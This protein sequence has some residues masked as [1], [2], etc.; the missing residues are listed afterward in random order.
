[1]LSFDLLSGPNK[2]LSQKTWLGGILT[3]FTLLALFWLIHTEYL[4]FSS[5]RVT[6]TIYVDNTSKPEPIQVNLS[7][8]LRNAPCSLITLDLHDHL[9]H[10][11]EDI[12]MNKLIINEQGKPITRVY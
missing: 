11:Q 7:L 10:E 4:N 9:G 8:K 2:R 6:K 12:P 1:M 5:N 3:L